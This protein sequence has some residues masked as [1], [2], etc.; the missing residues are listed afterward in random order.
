MVLWHCPHCAEPLVPQERRLSCANHHSFDIARQGYVNLLPA[1]FKHSKSPGDD[2][3]MLQSRRRFLQAGHYQ[4]LRDALAQLHS[5]VVAD[6]GEQT[7]TGL[8]MGGGDGYFCAA[9]NSEQT[10]WWLSDI[11]KDAVRMAA[12]QLP[13]ARCAVASSYKLPLADNSIDW[14][15]RNFA[16]SQDQE[17]QRVLRAK[18]YYCLVTPFD[19]HLL[20]LRECLYQ[21]P[22]S[23][24]SES[25]VA[26]FEQIDQRR[27]HYTFDLSGEQA[28]GDLLA[29]TPMAW[30]SSQAQRQQWLARSDRQVTAH[31]LI[32]LYRLAA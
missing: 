10:P 24:A 9:L 2:K 3:T 4:P 19:D 13:R 1:N 27:V 32:R 23:H 29:M 11:S 15:L 20:E 12:T 16:P 8:D 21:Q 5:T 30:R 7:F 14:V 28:C 6:I 31:F 18:G 25:V 17:V 22:K 26:P